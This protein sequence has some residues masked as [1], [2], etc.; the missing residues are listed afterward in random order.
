MQ[1]DLNNI[2]QVLHN[3]NAWPF[4]EAKRI[5]DS[6]KNKKN[7]KGYILFE[8]G[9]GP[10]GL[11]H[12][13]TFTEVART[14]MVRKAF[15]KISDIPTKLICFSDDMDGLRKVPLDIPNS[16]M[17]QDNLNRPLSAIPDP[18]EQEESYAAYMNKKLC[19]FLDRF[20]F[21]Y[22]FISAT[23]YY[24]SGKFDEMMMLV[25][26]R[27][28]QIM[29]LMLPTLRD[30]RRKTYSPFM[31]ISSTGH[32]LQVAIDR[33][34]KEQGLVYYTLDGR[35]ECSSV[36]GGK[37][38]LQWK[39]DFG[40]R[41]AHLDVDYEMY[42]KD[43]LPNGKIY[44]SVC[45]IL[46][47]VEP[48]QLFYELFL[49]EDSS[50]IS[51]SKGKGIGVDDW[52]RYAPLESLALFIHASPSKPKRLHFD[53]IPKSVDEYLAW[54]KKYHQQDLAQ[55]L[56]N[57]LYYVHDGKVPNID[58]GGINF[59]LLLNLVSVCNTNSKE[60]LLK[61]LERYVSNATYSAFLDR[62]L[63]CAINY[64]TDFVEKKK[65]YLSPNQQQKLLLEEI[66]TYLANIQSSD[67]EA[68]EI[69]TKIYEIGKNAQYENLRDYF[70]D[71]YQ[72]LLGQEEGPRLGSFIKLFGIEQ[73]LD[74]IKQKNQ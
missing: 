60:V 37:C 41:W 10:S 33:I 52:L 67:V 71:L 1:I 23:D 57:P 56:V 21:D 62:L 14:T 34:D 46:G 16:A 19:S 13:G 47:G 36:K 73:T 39:P 24:K 43:H 70:K 74:L 66:A 32:V 29:D 59:N 51:K 8:T 28:E 54:N 31:P 65:K 68:D 22:Q 26:E 11:P 58:I 27:Y 50:K 15:E 49:D 44:S 61:F 63:D 48:V 42:G 55:Q 18:F 45:R 64:Y 20:E 5:L 6:I 25:L 3:S 4:I 38:K 17:L 12:I 9:Y 53:V 40:M 2:E 30:E 35:E 69:Q 72:I 7:Q